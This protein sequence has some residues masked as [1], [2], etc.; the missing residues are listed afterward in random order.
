MLVDGR[1]DD[2]AVIGAIGGDASTSMGEL[3]IAGGV[4]GPLPR[5]SGRRHDARAVCVCRADAEVSIDRP[6]NLIRYSIHAI[7]WSKTVATHIFG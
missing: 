3:V 7:R 2:R 1:E 5:H 6:V 4:E